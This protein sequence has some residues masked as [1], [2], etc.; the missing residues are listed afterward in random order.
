MELNID[1]LK[2]CD[3]KYYIGIPLISDLDYDILKEKLKKL[4][5]NDYYFQTIGSLKYKGEKTKLP[6]IL[7][8]LEKRKLNNIEKWIKDSNDDLIVSAKLDGA[9]IFIK[10][11]NGKV[12]SAFNRGDGEFGFDLT[13]KAQIFCKNIL[14]KDVL[15]LR[16][17]AIITYDN[18]LKLNSILKDEEQ[19]ANPRNAVSGILNRDD[20]FGCEYISIIVYELINSDFNEENKF[21]FLSTIE[22]LNIVPY[23]IMKLPRIIDDKISNNIVNMLLDFMQILKNENYDI[24]GLVISKNNTKRENV[25]IPKNKIAFKVNEDG[26]ETEVLDVI[27]ETSRTGKVK[28]VILIKPLILNGATVSRVTGFNEK[29]ISLN[30]IGKGSIIKVLRSGDVIPYITDIIKHSINLNIPKT[31]PECFFPLLKDGVE[32]ICC[33]EECN[34]KNIKFLEYFTKTLGIESF[35]KT[36]LEKLQIKSIQDLFSLKE[37]NI[38]SIDGFGKKKA[39]KIISEL[40]KIIKNVNKSKLLASFGISDLSVKTAEKILEKIDNFEDVFSKDELFFSSIEGI[41]EKNSKKF[42][43]GLLKSQSLYNYLISIGLT[44]EEDTKNS[45]DK[46]IS[47]CFT[48]TAPIGRK[49]LIKLSNQMGYKITDIGGC[50]YLVCE[51][52]NGNSSKLKKAKSKGINIISYD[53]FMKKYLGM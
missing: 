25:K 48:G 27:W 21:E 11:E 34:V 16:C 28:P 53:F 6:Y 8:S 45:F 37:E 7:G 35:S 18:F 15:E 49:E 44:L 12:V 13:K 47:F 20:S 33:N 17:E 10:Y 36:S 30:K 42:V 1:F 22:N 24:D 19:Y 4:H 29:Y 43:E 32:L 39:E 41:G 51:D 23:R 52:E 2:K 3:E 40:K 46:S 26:Q 31:C 38:V 5:P 9:S 14:Y 50:H